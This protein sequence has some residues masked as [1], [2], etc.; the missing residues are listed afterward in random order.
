MRRNARRGPDGRVT[1]A[2]ARYAERAQ[3]LGAERTLRSPRARRATPPTAT[4]SSPGS[5]RPA[6][7]RVSSRASEEAPRRSQACARARRA[8]A[9]LGRRHAR[10]RRRRRLD[11]ARARW[12][13]GVVWS[14]SLQAGCVRMT[15]R[16]LG[17]DMVATERHCLRRR[18][19]RA[20]RGR[21]GRDRGGDAAGR[22]S[23]RHR[24]DA[25]RDR[26]WGYDPTSSTSRASRANSCG[27]QEPRPARM[28]LAERR[29]CRD[30][31]P[32]AR[33]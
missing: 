1:D 5:R 6:S 9:R 31:S 18:R 24:D 17:E 7:S 22:G 29:R 27:T 20:A 32:L 30:W 8:G 26:A 13:G 10:D 4:T 15:E 3:V 12:S 2:L 16:F 19:R 25:G 14:S 11:R 33:R 23:R 28:T 21:A